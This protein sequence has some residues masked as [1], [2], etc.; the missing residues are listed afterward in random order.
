MIAENDTQQILLTPGVDFVAWCVDKDPDTIHLA[1]GTTN[2]TPVMRN[3][4]WHAISDNGKYYVTQAPTGLSGL[5][6]SEGDDFKATEHTIGD[7]K[8]LFDDQNIEK[9]WA[10]QGT[11][12]FPEESWER[13]T[14]AASC[15]TSIQT[16]SWFAGEWW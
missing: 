1:T 11:D 15:Y 6:F 14:I 10:Y 16:P 7:W 13:T 4:A 3:Q 2:T 5:L 12:V 9:V 8:I